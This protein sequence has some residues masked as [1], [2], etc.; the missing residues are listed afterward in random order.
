MAWA[1]C[2]LVD[3]QADGDGAQRTSWLHSLCVFSL[4]LHSANV[5]GLAIDFINFIQVSTNEQS[6][7]I[8]SI[9]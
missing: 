3:F 5:C 4:G 1:E 7:A 6:N 2:S 9:F 8:Y